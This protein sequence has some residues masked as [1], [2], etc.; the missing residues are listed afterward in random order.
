VTDVQTIGLEDAAE[1][2]WAL[3]A[4]VYRT[5]PDAGAVVTFQSRWAG[6]LARLQVEM[7]AVFDE[8]ARHLGARVAV[9][10]P[11]GIDLL[12]SGNCGFLFRD[13]ALCLGFNKDRAVFNTE[14]LAKCC[15]A[16]ALAKLT[17]KPV[18]RIPLYVR[19]IA[20][21]RLAADRKRAAEAWARGEVP[22]GVGAY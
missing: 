21:R 15:Q 17:G 2:P 4:A 8:Q 20:G 12:R 13:E 14:L 1:G 11:E 22:N 6:I 5:R 19:Y 7:P 9:L 16:Y 18:G 3:H 10:S